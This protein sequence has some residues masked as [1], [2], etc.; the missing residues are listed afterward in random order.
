MKSINLIMIICILGFN[1]GAYSQSDIYIGSDA[2]IFTFTGSQIAIFGNIINDARGGF[3]HQ[4]G[5]DVYLVRHSENGSGSSSIIDGPLSQSANDNYNDEGSFCKFWNFYTN[6][7]VGESIPSGTIIN[8]NSGTGHI[9][10]EQEVRVSN[11]HNVVNG[12]IWTPRDDWRHSFV[13]YDTDQ[14]K[15]IGLND[16]KHVDGYVAKSGSSD[17]EFPIGDGKV[18][19]N[20]GI[21]SPENGIYKAAYFSQSPFSG[22]IGI[23]G[24]DINL[25]N[26]DNIQDSIFKV[27]TKEF[28]DIDGTA[29]TKIMLS[30][31][32]KLEGYSEWE[33]DFKDYYAHSIV[34]TGFDGKWRNLGIKDSAEL[35][36]DSN[37]QFK[38]TKKSI[39]DSLFTLYTWAATDSINN[40]DISDELT[41]QKINWIE[42]VQLDAKQVNYSFGKFGHGTIALFDLLGNLIETEKLAHFDGINSYTLKK[43]NLIKGV[44]FIVITNNSDEILKL[45]FII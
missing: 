28:W 39:P 3:N 31:Q 10:I 42:F 32:N 6:N 15:C 19:R 33:N 4:N 38:N 16:E 23:S 29:N 34:I 8:F 9:R 37:R 2:A 30:S 45:N 7:T 35:R 12:M 44:Y 40:T 14:S 5:G 24:N 26:I 41:F 17:F 13:H 36:Y 1:L 27:S 11:I 43:Q 21:I 25:N 20:C 18:L 22:T